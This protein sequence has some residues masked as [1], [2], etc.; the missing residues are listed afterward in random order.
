MT[1]DHNFCYFILLFSPL[2]FKARR[3]KENE[4]AKIVIK[5]HAFLF[6]LRIHAFSFNFA[7]WMPKID[8]VYYLSIYESTCMVCL[9]WRNNQ[10]TRTITI[11][12]SGQANC[13]PIPKIIFHFPIKYKNIKKFSKEASSS[14]FF[15]IWGLTSKVIEGHIRSFLCKKVNLIL[16][17]FSWDES[18]KTLTCVLNLMDN[19][20]HLFARKL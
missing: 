12:E 19:F 17:K 10:A 5:S 18:F 11:L 13:I 1:F 9:Q 15:M 7:G 16:Y 2:F 4:E 14:K 6:H 3:E 8:L 20:S